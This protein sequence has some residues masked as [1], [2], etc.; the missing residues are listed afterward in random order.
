[1]STIHCLNRRPGKD[2]LLIVVSQLLS[3]TPEATARIATYDPTPK[4]VPKMGR[5]YAYL[6]YTF[7]EDLL[8]RD[9]LLALC[10]NRWIDWQG[11]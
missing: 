5:A 7:Q 10:L 1:M 2:L 11:M 8:L 4:E 9:C 3:I 6:R